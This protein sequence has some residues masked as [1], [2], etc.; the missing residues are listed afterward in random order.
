MLAQMQTSLNWLTLLWSV[1]ALILYGLSLLFRDR[2]LRL[3]ALVM[4]GLCLVRLV[5]WDM[6]RADM[7]LRG[8]V[9]TGVGVVLVTMNIVSTRFE[10]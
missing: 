5:G 10:R 3:T 7:T 4:L 8:I 6:R 9:F 1:E 2:P